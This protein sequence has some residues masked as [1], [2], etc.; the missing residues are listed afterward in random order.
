MW[1]VNEFFLTVGTVYIFQHDIPHE[2]VDVDLSNEKSAPE[3]INK[4][5]HKQ[6][7]IL[8]DGSNVVFEGYVTVY[9]IITNYLKNQPIGDNFN[10]G[11][12]TGEKNSF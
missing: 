10:D 5:P 2:L 1:N 3:F 6:V 4:F 7:P 12:I 8:V 9:V 11:T